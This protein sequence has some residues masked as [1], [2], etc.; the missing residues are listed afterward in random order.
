MKNFSKNV[1]FKTEVLETQVINKSSPLSS[2][3]QYK[4]MFRTKICTK[5]INK[6]MFKRY[7][8]CQQT[9]FIL[10]TRNFLHKSAYHIIRIH[11]TYTIHPEQI[12]ST[13]P[14]LV[15]NNDGATRDV[16]KKKL[17]ID[18]EATY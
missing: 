17:H 4:S 16:K 11:S 1:I 7:S 6:K 15:R 10:L 12:N 5:K 2:S 9:I 18:V 8:N 13:C 14:E 3:E